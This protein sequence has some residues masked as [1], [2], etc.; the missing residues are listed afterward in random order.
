MIGK[1]KAF[2]TKKTV[3]DSKVVAKDLRPPDVSGPGCDMTGTEPLGLKRHA[4]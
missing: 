1:N 3:A 4:G 2:P